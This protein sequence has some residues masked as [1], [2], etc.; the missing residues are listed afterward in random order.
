MRNK[1]MRTF[2]T[3][4]L[5]VILGLLFLAA[6]AGKFLA[7]EVWV[8]KFSKWGYPEN[9]YLLIGITELLAAILL[10]IP[11]LTKYAAMFLVIIMIGAAITHMIHQEAAEILRPGIFL[12]LLSALI[13]L[14][15]EKDF[16]DHET[17]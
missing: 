15:R 12:V 6:G 4:T 5:Q 11:K 1:K 13:F 10:F 8:E 14:K 7:A 17:V 9:F 16:P 3:W 2:G